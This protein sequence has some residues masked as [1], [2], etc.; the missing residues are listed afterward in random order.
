MA[1]GGGVPKVWVAS[2]AAISLERSRSTC[3]SASQSIC[4][5]YGSTST[6]SGRK[7]RTT[8]APAVAAKVY[9]GV[10]TRGRSAVPRSSVVARRA[11]M[12]PSV[13]LLTGTQF[14]PPR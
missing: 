13:A 1:G 6:N 14:T 11:A 7:P 3:S 9:E 5:A 12:I 8:A 4:H 2:T 10:T